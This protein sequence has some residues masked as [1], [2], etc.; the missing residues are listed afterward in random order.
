M[1][2]GVLRTVLRKSTGFSAEGQ[3]LLRNAPSLYHVEW[4]AIIFRFVIFAVFLT[5]YNDNITYKYPT[6]S[7]IRVKPNPKNNS[8]FPN[9]ISLYD[10][11]WKSSLLENFT[12]E[13][14][15]DIWNSPI[16]HRPMSVAILYA[17]C[18]NNLIN[19]VHRIRNWKIYFL[20]LSREVF[21][22]SQ[23]FP[24]ICCIIGYDVPKN[25]TGYL[26][27]KCRYILTFHQLDNWWK[28]Y[29]KLRRKWS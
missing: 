5:L 3:S 12:V 15:A 28:V 4:V 1:A 23:Q 7:P 20:G 29:S 17:T 22:F 19:N 18:R 10:S 2:A 25:S 6:K 21:L 24:A 27:V 9:H 16:L 14:S 13:M 8:T 11:D 26:E